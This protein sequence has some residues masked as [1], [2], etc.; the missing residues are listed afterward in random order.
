MRIYKC[1]KNQENRRGPE[2][3]G[4]VSSGRSYIYDGSVKDLEP[5]MYFCTPGVSDLP[6]NDYCFV[7]IVSLTLGNIDRIIKAYDIIRCRL[8][9]LFRINGNWA[10]SWSVEILK[11][12]LDYVDCN[13]VTI[14]DTT[15]TIPNSPSSS[16]YIPIIFGHSVA[17]LVREFVFWNGS[18][19]I[20]R[21]DYGQTV[22]IRFYKYPI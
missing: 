19:W 18:N 12:D 13:V 7:D 20:I 22:M 15:V 14:K 5:G 9:T 4:N 1:Y 8:Y 6:L 10:S 17:D 16:F 11:S 2:L 21:S 3:I